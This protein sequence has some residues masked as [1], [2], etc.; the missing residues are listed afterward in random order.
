MKIYDIPS[1][2]YVVKNGD[3]LPIEDLRAQWD[4]LTIEEKQGW[5][6]TTCKRSK[7]EAETVIDWVIESLADTGY[8][9]MDVMLF[10]QL[11]KN[12]VDKL[13]TVLDDLFDNTAADV[14][15]P[16]KLIEVENER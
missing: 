9:E 1:D 2:T 4:K 5:Y 10:E 3:T 13:Q 14:Y 11:P 8:E 15:Y 12:A 16:S 7:I 6:T